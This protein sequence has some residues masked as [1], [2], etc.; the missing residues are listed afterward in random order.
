M[1]L[2]LLI[3]VG[4]CLPCLV[5]ITL[6]MRK[7]RFVRRL[8]ERS[9]A[10]GIAVSLLP[11]SGFIVYMLFRP[12]NSAAMLLH[13]TLIWIFCSITG[14]IVE[15][16]AKKKPPV[17]VTGITAVTLSL[18]LIVWGSILASDM[19]KTEYTVYSGKIGEPFRIAQISDVHLGAVFDSDGL[20]SRLDEIEKEKPDIL[21]VTGDFI[22]S[23]TDV[24]DVEAACRALGEC[25]TRYGVFFVF[26]N[27]DVGTR[28]G[29][30][31][32]ETKE[33][34][35]MLETYGVTVL[36]DG[37]IEIPG[38]VVVG[39]KDRSQRD[40]ADIAELLSGYN[41]VFSIVLD[42]QP[43]DTKAESGAGADLVLSGHTHGGQF[44]PLGLV[45][46][47]T[48]ANELLYGSRSVGGTTFIVTSGI[49]DWATTFRTGCSSEYVIID[50]LPE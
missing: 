43:N 25:K 37:A 14:F 18:V 8:S 4:L 39:R 21:V 35:S 6:K 12:I 22:D 2:Q 38:A 24:D 13:L 28:F 29:R 20:K 46:I 11:A 15:K 30:S 23:Y 45:G 36:N 5:Y 16:I 3:T 40:R 26:G 33:L 41:D 9:R 49:A 44:F 17:Y 31:G 7:F 10:A 19:R 32:L 27:H 42:H 48:G 50:V 1:F 34:S 47:H